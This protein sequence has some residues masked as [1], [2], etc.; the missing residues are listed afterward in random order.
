MT[1]LATTFQRPAHAFGL[2]Q[3]R[4][5]NFPN[6][7]FTGNNE[8]PKRA[9]DSV[10]SSRRLG[11][12]ADFCN[13]HRAIIERAI[14]RHCNLSRW[15]MQSFIMETRCCHAHARRCKRVVLYTA[16]IVLVV[17]DGLTRFIVCI[18]EAVE[19]NCRGR[20][21]M[22]VIDETSEGTEIAGLRL[23]PTESADLNS[24]RQCLRELA[25]KQYLGVF[26]D[27]AIAIKECI[28][29]LKQTSTT[30]P[31]LE[32]PYLRNRKQLVWQASHDLEFVFFE[33]TKV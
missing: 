23:S 20:K 18:N 1:Q 5:Y 25:I 33:V 27:V 12:G 17:I 16:Q 8:A 10:A 13:G 7:M 3:H 14:D 9:P 30:P 24:A 21:I 4:S 15:L 29:R 2:A 22:L 26:P 31:Q 6:L 32:A 28:M 11:K 19:Y